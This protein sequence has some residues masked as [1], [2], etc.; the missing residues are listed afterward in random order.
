MPDHHAEHNLFQLTSDF[1]Q[2]TSQNIFLTGKAGTGKTTFLKHIREHC[3]KK[4][5]VVAPTG[6]A[7]INA[8]G[9]TAH[10]FF[11]LPLGSFIPGSFRGAF[12]SESAVTDRHHLLSRLRL[13]NEKRELIQN[14]DLVIIDEV[15]MLRCDML[16]A[17]DTVLRY[18]RRN[19]REPFGGVQMLFI[20]DLYQ[21]PPV[22]KENEWSLLKEYYTTQFF[23]GAQVFKQ[24]EP[25]CIELKKVYR[26]SDEKFIHLLNRVRNN[27]VDDDDFEKLHQRYNPT[28]HPKS[29]DRFITLTTHN[30]KADDINAKELRRLPGKEFLCEATVER[31]FPDRNFPV[32]KTLRLKAGAQIMFVRNDTEEKKYFNGKIG[33]IKGLN[34]DGDEEFLEVEFPEEKNVIRVQ[35]VTWQNIRYSFNEAENKI[36]EEQLGSFTQYPIRLAWAVT[37]HKSQGLTFQNVVIDAGAAF[38]AGQVYVALSR[39]VSLEGIV[40]LSRIPRNVIMTDEAIVEFSRQQNNISALLPLLEKEKETFVIR[41]TLAL[42]NLQPAFDK[43]QELIVYMG[44]RKIE[45]KEK[46][47]SGLHAIH[48]SLMKLKEL[49]EKFQEQVRKITAEGLNESA[50]LQLND[51]ISK[52][53]AYFEKE[54]DEKVNDELE[55]LNK[56]IQQQNKVRKL[57]KE[58]KSFMDFFMNFTNRFRLQPKKREEKIYSVSVSSENRTQLSDE[59]SEY[60]FNLLKQIRRQFSNEENVAPFMI[61]HD[62]SLKEM[63]NYLPQTFTDLAMIKG[64]G[65]SKLKKY[66]ET[67]LTAIQKF[68]RENGLPSQIHLKEEDLRQAKISKKN[69]PAEEGDTYT[70]SFRLFQSGKSIEEVAATRGMA[71]S[72]IEG[73]LSMFVKSG[74]LDVFRFVTEEKFEMITDALKSLS[75]LSLSAVKNMLG[76]AVTY[77]EIRFVLAANEF[78][79]VQAPS[80]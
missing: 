7:A 80:Q 47:V 77:S 41:K 49:A 5:V 63:A 22:V 8:G 52:A 24:A 65:D 59:N 33:L 10:S 48:D 79:R 16:D 67:F 39:C 38:A 78:R 21:L 72:T 11:Q 75:Q 25:I 62:S 66:G 37:I 6:V 3:D 42:F 13:S 61:C 74:E 53:K 60:L 30:Y 45:D 31:D 70:R 55:K 54:L 4:M 69:K 44:E 73:H 23:F 29:E 15:S 28:F 46:I 35:K 20:G 2:H 76:D 14:L 12:H 36:N 26:Q 17:I 51:R 50:Q 9:V 56:E 57:L 43:M 34:H 64:M 1:V 18:V 19:Q 32:E 68:S 58:M 40:L 27:D 71:V